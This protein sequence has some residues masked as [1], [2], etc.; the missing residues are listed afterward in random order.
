MPRLVNHGCSQNLIHLSPLP[1]PQAPFAVLF[2][3]AFSEEKNMLHIIIANA[4][5]YIYFVMREKIISKESALHKQV[6]FLSDKADNWKMKR[7]KEKEDYAL[8]RKVMSPTYY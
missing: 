2:S 4:Y 8:P 1:W 5:V 3:H 6:Y 7:T